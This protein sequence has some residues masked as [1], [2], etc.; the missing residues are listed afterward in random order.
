MSKTREKIFIAVTIVFCALLFAVRLTGPLWHAVIGVLL[1]VT[2]V[3]HLCKQMV[4]MKYRKPA[5]RWVDEILLAATV[6]MFVTGML[7]HPMQGVFIIKLLHKLS[8]IVF[9]LGT[10]AHVVQHRAGRKGKV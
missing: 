8:A 1:T 9:I 7:L 3:G 2:V 5:I 10:V 4:K 6:V